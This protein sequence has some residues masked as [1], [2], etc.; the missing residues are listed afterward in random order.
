MSVICVAAYIQGLEGREGGVKKS[1][2]TYICGL[3]TSAYSP[4]ASFRS[5]K[6]KKIPHSY[7]TS[8]SKNVIHA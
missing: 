1:P 2:C 6:Q 8:A 5:Y 4:P 7:I 3:S